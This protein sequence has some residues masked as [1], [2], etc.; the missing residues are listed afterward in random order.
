MRVGGRDRRLPR[1]LTGEQGMSDD[2][3]CTVPD[4]CDRIVWRNRYYGLPYPNHAKALEENDGLAKELGRL[5]AELAER[6]RDRDFWMEEARRFCAN[7][8]FYRG[9]LDKCAGHFGVEAYTA[10]DGTVFDSP[11]RLK[12]PDLVAAERQRAR[13]PDHLME[14][15]EE[16]LA[17]KR[18]VNPAGWATDAQTLLRDLLAAL[19]PRK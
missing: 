4:H 13:L 17:S 14:R 15:A 5:R 9:L 7:E 1:G 12:I 2:Y 8:E 18:V 16:L 3:V 6:E 19:E 10:D 11:V